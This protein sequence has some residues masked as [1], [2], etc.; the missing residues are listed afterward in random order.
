MHVAGKDSHHLRGGPPVHRPETLEGVVLR[1]RRN[2]RIF[3]AFARQEYPECL[4][5][6]EEQLRA[7]NGLAE[8]AIHV[9]GEN[10]NTSLW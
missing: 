1:E 5:I 4:Q 10:Y 6:I 2:W 7:C 8:Y 9:K 3:S